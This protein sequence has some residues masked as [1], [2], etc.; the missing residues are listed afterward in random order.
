MSTLMALPVAKA[1][2]AADPTLP[3]IR[4]EEGFFA[5]ENG[6]A[7]SGSPPVIE[8]RKRDTSGEMGSPR[9]RVRGPGVRYADLQ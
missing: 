5:S 4:D 7:G 2:A 1:A 6:K 9:K 8:Q 3:A